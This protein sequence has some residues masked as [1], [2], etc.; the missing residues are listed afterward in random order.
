[1]GERK[2]IR[3]GPLD[4]RQTM[5]RKPQ[6]ADHVRVEQAHRVARRRIPKTGVK[7]LG[8]SGAAHDVTPLDNAYRRAGSR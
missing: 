7:F 5:L 2:K 1:M 3:E 8:D 6:I 4:D